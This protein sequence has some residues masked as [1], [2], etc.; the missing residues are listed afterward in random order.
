MA[1]RDEGA[2][3]VEPFDLAGARVPEVHRDQPLGR[4][5]ANS[6]TS[7]FHTTLMLA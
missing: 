3:G 2:F 7:R 1:D 6:A 4:A 5:P